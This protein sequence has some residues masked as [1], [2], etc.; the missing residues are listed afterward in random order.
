MKTGLWFLAAFIILGGVFLM[1]AQKNTTV[2]TIPFQHPKDMTKGEQSEEEA[3]VPVAPY[4]YPHVNLA[5][6]RDI[7]SK[8]YNGP[9]Y[10]VNYRQERLAQKAQQENR[11][12]AS[13]TDKNETPEDSE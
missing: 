13:K 6:I 11:L 7:E 4:G 5:R 10:K 8:P 9:S 3:P 2:A 12:P 1:K